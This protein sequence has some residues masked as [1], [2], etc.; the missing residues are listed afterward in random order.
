MFLMNL[1]IGYILPPLALNL[2][3]ASSRFDKPLPQVYRAVLPF[4]ALLLAVLALIT[5]APG[6]SLLFE[7]T[8]IAP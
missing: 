4:L 7:K 8:P 3:L 2:F 6:L 1:E 5:Y